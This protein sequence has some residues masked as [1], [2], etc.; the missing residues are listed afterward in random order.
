M[1]GDP[2]II[3]FTW[4]TI[5]PTPIIFD[6]VCRMGLKLRSYSPE[7]PTYITYMVWRIFPVAESL[8]LLRVGS[9]VIYWTQHVPE[10]IFR[11]YP[12]LGEKTSWNKCY[13]LTEFRNDMGY[14]SFS[15]Q[16]TTIMKIPTPGYQVS[17]DIF[18]NIF[19]RSS[20]PRLKSR[21][22]S[23]ERFKSAQLWSNVML[24]IRITLLLSQS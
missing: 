4:R 5:C 8:L 16:L 18:I 9:S 12:L 15:I 19:T 23:P 17:H 7:M 2:S 20:L 11:K 3:L 1:R 14:L 22:Y 13:W 21:P 6:P 24:G 10:A